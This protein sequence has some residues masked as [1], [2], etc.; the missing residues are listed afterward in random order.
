MN[1]TVRPSSLVLTLLIFRA[2]SWLTEL[3]L[4]SLLIIEYINTI[5]YTIQEVA[6]LYTTRKVKDILY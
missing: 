3:D 1:N 6:K 2:Y 4:P 5:K